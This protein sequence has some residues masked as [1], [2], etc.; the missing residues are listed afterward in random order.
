MKRKLFI[1]IAVLLIVTA[2]FALGYVASAAGTGPL[3]LQPSGTMR[4]GAVSATNG[5]NTTSTSFVDVPGLSSSFSIPSLKQ[6]DVVIQ[7]SGEMNSPNQINVRALVDGSLTNPN[8]FGNGPQLFYGVG[9]GA[10]AQGFNFYK[11]GI[12]PGSH[13]VKIQWEGFSGQQF[14]SYRSMVYFVNIR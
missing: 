14:M 1:G 7:F 12:G 10:T 4:V 11:F 3:A 8:S 2:T 6:G 9:G 5:I 13:T